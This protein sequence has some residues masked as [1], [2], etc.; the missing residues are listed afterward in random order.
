MNKNKGLKERERK[1][2]ESGELEENGKYG[3]D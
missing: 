3:R 2:G 1:R